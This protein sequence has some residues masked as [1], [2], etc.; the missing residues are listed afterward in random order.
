[1]KTRHHFLSLPLLLSAFWFGSCSENTL[2]NG[3]DDPTPDDGVVTRFCSGTDPNAT[4]PLNGPKKTSMD[5]EGSFYWTLGDKIW[6]K[7][8]SSTYVQDDH[9]NI[10]ATQPS[11]DFWIPGNLTEQSYPVYYTG[12]NDLSTSSQ[13]KVKIADR[14]VQRVSNNSEHFAV[15]GDCGIATA[16]K[17]T[18]NNAYSFTLT[19]K[20]SYLILVPFADQEEAGSIY[21]DKVTVTSNNTLCG[22]YTFDDNGI[23]T[24]SVTGGGKT[25]TLTTGESGYGFPVG[26]A[27]NQVKCG[28][29][30]VIQPGTHTLTFTYHVRYMGVPMTS[31]HTVSA[32]EFA[33]NKYYRVAHKLNVERTEFMFDFP[34]TYYMWDAKQWYWYGQSNLTYGIIPSV[35]DPDRWFNTI[36]GTTAHQASNSACRAD[37]SARNMPCYNAMTWY[38][39]AGAYWDNTTVWYLGGDAHTG[40]LWLKRWNKISGKPGGASITNCASASGTTTITPTA[41]KPSNTADYF[42]LPALGHYSREQGGMSLSGVGTTGYYWSSSP[43]AG[44]ADDAY[45]LYFYSGVVRVFSYG[46]SDGYR[47]DGCIAGKRPN[48]TNWFQ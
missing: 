34:D 25:I 32:R 15:S 40:G 11:A 42:F 6:V 20:A 3:S 29:Y 17:N 38:L 39:S 44:L 36:T 46:S 27:Q 23:N 31:T 21:L 14:Q 28:G 1:M 5:A 26:V 35:N 8:G 24:S 41:G 18:N 47:S 22:T 45:N 12:Q 2:P 37:G 43:N 30:M 9:S 33:V 10:N 7:T 13:L 4:P 48:G 16:E 19:H